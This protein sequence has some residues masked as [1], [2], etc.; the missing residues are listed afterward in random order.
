MCKLALLIL[1][2]MQK[3]TQHAMQERNSTSII[4]SGGEKW[5][6]INLWTMQLT[7]LRVI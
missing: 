6:G 1:S 4:G 5:I 7:I 3:N 2:T